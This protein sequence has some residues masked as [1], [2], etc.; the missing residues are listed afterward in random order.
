MQQKLVCPS[1]NADV[2]AGNINMEQMV[3]VCPVCDMVFNFDSLAA[4][5]P[6]K[7]KR[8]RPARLPRG[9]TLKDTPTGVEISWRWFSPS[10]FFL[11]FF[12]IA[13]DAFLVFWYSMVGSFSIGGMGAI[14]VLFPLVHVAIGVSLTYHVLS[15]WLNRTVIDL[16]PD[17]VQVRTFPVPHPW[18]TVSLDCHDIEQVYVKQDAN[19]FSPTSRYQ[20][21]Y[22][23]VARRYGGF[24]DT[25]ARNVPRA[26]FAH[27][28]EQEIESFL[29]I[30]DADVA[31]SL[32]H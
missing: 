4:E 19:H 29:G 16:S 20:T 22:Q 11:T 7:K 17:R 13:W 2:P 8:A 9:F 25:L 24:E 27:A 15:V 5:Y 26:D 31:G 1:C 23:V 21:T 30:P 32:R 3:A 12:V 10:V 18:H 28:V 14:F 6:K